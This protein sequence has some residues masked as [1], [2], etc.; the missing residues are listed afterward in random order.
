MAPSLP[1]KPPHAHR[2][3]L[4]FLSLA[5]LFFFLLYLSLT[6]SPLPSP[7]PSSRN[8]PA[9]SLSDPHRLFLSL[10][11]GANASIAGHLRALTLRPHLAG[12]PSAAH[13]ASYVLVH[14][15]S[16][17]LRTLVADY[18][19]LL[20]YPAS[21]SLALLRPDGALL[22]PLPLAEPADPEAAAVPPYHAYS[23]SGAAMAPG[24][25]IN[26]GR[27]E[28]YRALDR[29]GVDVK[30][31]VV[32]VRRGGGYRGAVVVRAAARGA[33]AVLMFKAADRGGVERGTVLLGGV[34]DPLTPGWAAPAADDGGGERLDA[35]EEEVRR[36]FPKIPSMPVAEAVA[37]E[38]L[39]TLGGPPMPPAW[40]DKLPLVEES[41]V[42]PGPT[43]I[44]L[45]YQVISA[46]HGFNMPQFDG[47]RWSSLFP[48]VSAVVGF[49]CSLAELF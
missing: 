16:A 49:L 4:A 22:R 26:Y 42:G 36:R 23:P 7:P 46:V 48:Y 24:V 43:L 15:R 17:G 13:A 12:T 25:Y 21:A 20:S 2:A 45:T 28:D 41:G 30:G 6:P 19:P 8:A 40:R 10:S 35:D 3:A 1:P 44:N 29:L 33:V 31:C 18:Y 39:R 37:M 38:I 9:D 32:I 11:P 34:G 5:L 27:E 14:L 47:C